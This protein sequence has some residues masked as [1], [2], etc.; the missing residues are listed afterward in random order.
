MSE[1]IELLER[2]RTPTSNG[3]QTNAASQESGYAT[4]STDNTGMSGEVS[5]DEYGAKFDFHTK[6]NQATHQLLGLTTL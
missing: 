1:T 5:F 4:H 3:V 2:M 6:A